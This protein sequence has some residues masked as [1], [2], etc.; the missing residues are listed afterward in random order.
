MNVTSQHQQSHHVGL[1]LGEEMG[2][3]LRLE[4]KRFSVSKSPD[5]R[6]SAFVFHYVSFSSSHLLG[7]LPPCRLQQHLRVVFHL[8]AQQANQLLLNRNRNLALLSQK[9]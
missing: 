2:F 9:V 3:S 8:K 6:R 7:E 5:S 4:V 1:N